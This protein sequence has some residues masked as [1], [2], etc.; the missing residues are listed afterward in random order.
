[1]KISPLLLES[2]EFPE[3]VISVALEPKSR[4][5]M[6]K[7]SKAMSRLL[8][9]D[10]SLKVKADKETGQTILSGMGELHLEI[11]VDRLL[12]EFQVEASVGEPE[13]AFRETTHQ[14][15]VDSLQACETNGR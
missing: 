1:M 14:A 7:L 11:V 5:E 13:V 9:E 12:R 8:R 2:M 4:D 3:P 10:P 15:G 6:D